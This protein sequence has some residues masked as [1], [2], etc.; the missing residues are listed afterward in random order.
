MLVADGHSFKFSV[1]V[2]VF[3]EFIPVEKGQHL[4]K[5]AGFF[6]LVLV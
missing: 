4:R 1:N 3:P 6:C 5:F 2:I